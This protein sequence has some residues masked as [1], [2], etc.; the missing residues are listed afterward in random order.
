[1]PDVLILKI[2][3]RSNAERLNLRVTET[4]IKIEKYD[5]YQRINIRIGKTASS[6]EYWMD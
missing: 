3:E 5:L 4:G 6:A 1:M 2:N